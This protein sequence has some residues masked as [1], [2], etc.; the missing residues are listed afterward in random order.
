M[1]LSRTVLIAVVSCL[2][3]KTQAQ[4]MTIDQ[5]VA[6][7]RQIAIAE[8]QR[9]GIPASI[10]LAQ[11]ILETENGNSDLV[12]KSNNHFGIKCKSSWTGPSV[13]HDDDARG[14][15]F[16]KYNTAE[17]SYRDHSDF[18]KNSDRYALL[19]KLDPLN[20]KD[21]A[22]GLRRAGY[23]TNPKYAQIL[24]GYIEQYHLQDYTLIAMGKL[25]PTDDG[26]YAANTNTAPVK[27]NTA[28]YVAPP[29]PQYPQGQFMINETKVVFAKQGT[30]LLAMAEQYHIS[31]SYLVD[32][33][34]LE[35][36][37]EL[38]KDQ[39]IYLQ[40]KR[41]TGG[42]AKHTVAPGE[43]LY[44]IA[45]AEGIRLSSLLEY[46]LLTEEMQPAIGEQLML[47]EKGAARPKLASEVAIITQVNY[48][49]PETTQNTDVA[50]NDSPVVKEETTPVVDTVPV[51]AEPAHHEGR[52]TH[53]VQPKET[54]YGIARKYEVALAQLQQ[55]NNMSSSDVKVGQELII[56]K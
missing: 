41:K 12:R 4:N 17:E 16:R 27:V 21:W 18:L 30:S 56:S 45:Q 39:L 13:T 5:Y 26:V 25:K 31:L 6:T 29:A 54:L 46:N 52:I 36:D 1:K 34:D 2:A 37:N 44:D 3:M 7:Y 50:V 20:Y 35:N 33:N 47:K 28:V 49:Q 32:F 53:I 38:M 40:R 51:V 42:S 43:S 22:Y 23:A 48:K 14:E 10:T 11:G 9:T 19:F 15:C 24:I 55:L 8:M